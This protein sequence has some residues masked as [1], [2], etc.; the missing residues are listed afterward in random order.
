MIIHSR[1]SAQ[2]DQ[3][4]SR[5]ARPVAASRASSS[6]AQKITATTVGV[7]VGSGSSRPTSSG[8][9]SSPGT[10]ARVRTQGVKTTRSAATKR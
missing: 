5:G 6:S 7:G 10:L 4:S 2:T 8:W 9:Y 1:Y 3:P